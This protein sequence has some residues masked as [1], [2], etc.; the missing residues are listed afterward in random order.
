MPV[1]IE[2]LDDRTVQRFL[3]TKGL[4]HGPADGVIGKETKSA[5]LRLLA[6]SMIS[7]SGWNDCRIRNAVEQIILK[8][9]G[10]YPGAVDGR[11]GP[12][13]FDAQER[14]QNKIRDVE[15]PSEAIAHQP[16]RWPRESG[17][18]EFYG[19][20]GKNQV[21]LELPYAMKLAWDTDSMVHRIQCHKKVHDSLGNIFAGILKEYG[22]SGIADL[23]LDLFGGCL[24]VRAKKGAK[25]YSM[26]S[27]GIAV[28]LDPENN[29]LRWGRPKAEFSKAD[30]EPFW[31]IV[32][33]EG[34]ISL[35][36]EK[37]YDWMHF[38]AA[39]F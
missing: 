26:H 12:L 1:C 31:R 24:A 29:Q 23:R 38:Q 36:R 37:N 25:S 20:V 6:N 33:R 4:Y 5:F 34:W 35:G 27:W 8:A 17:V 13:S 7:T 11:L 10:F 18:L 22:L 3:A 9:T 19:Q 21:A 32:E 16:N 2:L 14:Y 30:Y 39:R 28:D 15:P